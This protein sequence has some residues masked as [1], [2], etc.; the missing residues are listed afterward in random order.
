M[1][2][3]QSTQID[4]ICS[5]HHFFHYRRLTSGGIRDYEPW[6]KEWSADG[7]DM[8]EHLIAS[9]NR[10]VQPDHTVLHLGDLALCRARELPDLTRRLNG[11]IIL[12]RGN[13]DC[14][15][16]ACERA[17]MR[18]ERAV[19]V[20]FEHLNRE[21]VCR[22]DPAGF[23]E[24]DVERSMFLLHGHQHGRPAYTHC[25]PGVAARA[26]DVGVDAQRTTD[27]IAFPSGLFYA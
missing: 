2:V 15:K 13:H 27:P 18:A 23:T 21:V 10:V 6:R 19:I 17:G 7:P 5:D 12:V 26:I 3:L 25:T 20:R 14:T 22:H 1:P 24:E 16:A 4:W 11:T 8:D 9:W